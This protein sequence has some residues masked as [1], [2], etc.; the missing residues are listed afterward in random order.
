MTSEEL[1]DK[2]EQ[3]IVH[4]VT[5]VKGTGDKQYSD[6]DTQQFENKE[7]DQIFTDAEEEL[8]DIVNYCVMLDIRLRRLHEKIANDLKEIANGTT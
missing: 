2:V 8:I 7:L 6:G 3:F 5:R 1:A 4:A